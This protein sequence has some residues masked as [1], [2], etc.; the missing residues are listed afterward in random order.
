[1]RSVEPAANA[2][3]YGKI[4]KNL[5][6][7]HLLIKFAR[8]RNGIVGHP[9]FIEGNILNDKILETKDLNS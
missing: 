3:N 4:S 7:W 9:E 1:M 8:I 2:Q 5:N 6:L